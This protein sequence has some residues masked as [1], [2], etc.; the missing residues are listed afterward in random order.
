MDVLQATVVGSLVVVT[1]VG[2]AFVEVIS[3]TIVVT[4]LVVISMVSVVVRLSP[5][6]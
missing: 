4:T 2:W 6:N 1:M 5:F 3:V